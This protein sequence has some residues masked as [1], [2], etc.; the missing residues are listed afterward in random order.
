MKKHFLLIIIAITVL[1]CNPK[2]I[3]DCL[4]SEGDAVEQ[5][6]EVPFFD[7]L[8]SNSRTKVFVKSGPE[9]QVLIQTG[10]NLIDDVKVSVIDNTLFLE[11]ENGCNIFRDFEQ[12]K[13][14]VTSPNLVSIRN[15]SGYALESIGVLDYPNL[16]LLS[17]DGNNEDEFNTDGDFILQLESDTVILVNNNITN[18][19]LSGTVNTMQANFYGGDGR[20]D[21]PNLI[22]QDLSVLHRGT[23]KFIVNPQQSIRGEIRSTG[24]VISVNQPPIV[25]VEEFFTGRLIFQ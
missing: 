3:D 22:V 15:G 21:A 10:E 23:N 14:I 24:D 2:N 8:I 19:F 6:V 13:I 17:E 9:Q 18:Y 1:G 7:K 12:V 11:N 5:I 25:E 16:V 20:L 4:K